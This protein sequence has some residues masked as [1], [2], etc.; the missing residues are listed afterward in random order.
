MREV[1]LGSL[2]LLN[3]N[4]IALRKSTLRTAAAG[5]CLCIS[6]FASAQKQKRLP[7]P[8]Q[9]HR[10]GTMEL[11]NK[12]IQD[13]PSIV[14]KWQEEGQKQYQAYLQRKDDQ[15]GQ[16]IQAGEIIIPVVFHLV[17]SSTV[18][19]VIPDRD[20]YEQLEILN[21]DFAGHKA[22]YYKANGIFSPAFVSAIGNVPVRFVLAR[23]TPAGT[24][25]NGIERLVTTKTFTQTTIN[26]LKSTALGGLDPWDVSKYLNI[27]C[28]I[29]SDN[30]LG[31]ATF[32]FTNSASI[33]PQGVAIHLATLGANPCRGYYSPLYNEGATLSHEVG[34][35]LYLWHTFGDNAACNDL[36]FRIQSGWPLTPAASNDDTP[37]E[38]ADENTMYGNVSGLYTDGCTP[39]GMMY[40]NFMN[41]FDDRSLFFF[42]NGQK[43][44][45]V[46]T[47]DMYRA[48]LKTS[49]GGTPPA[50][51]TDAYLLSITPMGK[52]DNRSPI[53]NNTPIKA[54]IRNY[55]TTPLTSVTLN[56]QI[57]GGA[58]VPTTFP[59][60]LAALSDSTLV[61]GNIT[62]AIGNHTVVVY[63]SAPNGGAD[64]YLHKDT[65]TSRVN[66]RTNTLTAPF[67][68]DFNGAFFPPRLT[69]ANDLWYVNNPAG[70]NSWYLSDDYGFFTVG[71]VAAP[72]YDYNAPGQ[73]EDLVTPPIDF[74]TFDSSVLSFRVAH[75]R[76]DD[77]SYTWDGL[78]VQASNDGG[79]SWFLVYKK[80]GTD[81]E[82]Q[83]D[84]E[85]SAFDPEDDAKLWRTEKVN[86]TPYIGSGQ[87]L[88]F[89][90]RNINAYGNNIF[91]DDI[92]V[93]AAV[94]ATRDAAVL[95]VKGVPPF[96][97]NDFSIKP[98][99]TLANK[100]KTNLTTVKVN[101]R[102]D[103]N[104]VTTVTWNGNLAKGA[105]VDYAL[106]TLS[107]LP[108]GAHT[109]TVYTSEPN[110]GTDQDLTN[111]TIRIRFTIFTPVN[112]PI[113]QGFES[114]TFP[115]DGWGLS[116]SGSAYTWERNTLSS[117]EKAAS[118]WV[119]NY[120][121]TS[122]QTDNLYSPIIKI[123]TVDSI[124][125]HFDVAHATAVFPGSTALPMDTLEVLVT[126]DCGLTYTTV[127]KKWGIELQTLGDPNT[128]PVYDHTADP[129]GFVPNNNYWRKE[130]I[131]VTRYVN[132]KSSF[133]VIFK[134][135]S[136]VGNNT[137]L[138]NINISTV[139]LPAKLKSEGFLIYPNPF[140]GGFDVRHLIPPT[141][142]KGMVVI[143]ASGQIVYQK[144]YNGNA[145]NQIRVDLS[146]F[147]NG[148]YTLR[149]IY[150]TKVV[151]QRII[152]RPN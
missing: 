61:L 139:V 115:P 137:F 26:Q 60:T 25:T 133:Q 76:Y 28:A 31:I 92:G 113:V 3:Q 11:L 54:T 78:E 10:C 32:P 104:A 77:P 100:A 83:K 19:N 127:Y 108:A 138:D 43:E 7:D 48:S 23:R 98:I 118:A 68:E 42:T 94:Q 116:T 132:G 81:L 114:G 96:Q 71:A 47:M 140:S 39:S 129:I 30:L 6:L 121:S 141:N 85:A 14:G 49:D 143:N 90:F 152:K 62:G 122:G 125:V 151:T 57:D 144:S 59:L 17:G 134:N 51:V 102:V 38:K 148:I 20:I 53:L 22:D 70:G 117:T 44:R 45:V 37:P 130:F 4:F 12:I 64:N 27:W 91:I 126:S 35:Y 36:D 97:C 147:A 52:C 106:G 111:D 9:S 79:Q 119:R 142:L 8:H 107:N 87:K 136:N 80:T 58:V 112:A 89:R 105:T 131:D 74:T 103:N 146:R 149:M 46:A 1:T 84:T 88:I 67:T 15:S 21:N 50:P 93:S 13:D 128:A 40:M 145:A 82:T 2:L 120:R 101:Y 66:I 123:E 55:G 16:R 135:T 5:I 110:N 65:L 86:L 124:Y 99:I 63:T 95:A 34:H 56:V 72:N 73:F 109:L 69:T 29:F 75:A 24:G 18:L 150:D 41:Y 33:G